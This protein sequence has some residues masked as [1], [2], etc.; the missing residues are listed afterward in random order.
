MEKK[1]FCPNCGNEIDTEDVFCSNCGSQIIPTDKDDTASKDN[2]ENKGETGR[3]TSGKKIIIGV[4]LAVIICGLIFIGLYF[5]AFS[6]NAKEA[7]ETESNPNDITQ[8]ENTDLEEDDEYIFPNS[9][10]EY[11]TDEDV[12]DLTADE[13]ALARNE[14]IARHGRIFTDERYKSYFESKSWYEGTV[15]PEE[16]DANYENELNDIEKANIELIKKHE[17]L[18]AQDDSAN[19]YYASILREYQQAEKN[20]FSG[21]G[22]AYPHVNR[23]LLSYGSSVLFYTTIDLCNDG[24]PELFI[25]QLVD[26]D[27][28]YYDILDIYGYENGTPQHLNIGIDLGKSPLDPDDEMGFNDNYIICEDNLIKKSESEGAEHNITTYYELQKNSVTLFVKDGAIKNGDDYYRNTTGLAADPSDQNEYESILDR[29]KEKKDMTWKK[30]ADFTDNSGSQLQ[31]SS[32]SE[33]ANTYYGDFLRYYKEQEANG[34]TT[35]DLEL[36]N[37]IFSNTQYFPEGYTNSGTSLYYTVLDLANGGTP[38]LLIS[39]ENQLYGAYGIIEGEG[40]VV[41][42]FDLNMGEFTEYQICTDN[43]IRGYERA[44]NVV[45][46]IAYYRVDPHAYSATCSEAVYTDMSQFYFATLENGNWEYQ[47]AATE[48]D[49][50]EMEAKYPINEKIEWL[51]LSDF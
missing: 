9:D 36:I 32:V 47:S 23:N 35:P 44:G 45:R 31:S 46:I 16:F 19:K 28:P 7:K 1:T 3:K 6:H 33:L 40:Q 22:S 38:E 27:T 10:T 30:L 12:S 18:L 48:Q 41:P 11:L 26:G 34:F 4:I 25:S 49:F 8:T 50:R 13:L 29:Y 43:M 15:Q 2:N 51:K 21:N 17:G 24:V 20:G 14:I 5:F 39:D 42:L 37:P